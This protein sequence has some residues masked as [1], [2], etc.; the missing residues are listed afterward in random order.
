MN[1]FIY[2]DIIWNLFMKISIMN[3]LKSIQGTS[4]LGIQDII[5]KYFRNFWFLTFK[6]KS[7]FNTQNKQYP[8]NIYIYTKQSK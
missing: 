6:K 4:R 1:I 5:F 2:F 8:I 7:T 3:N